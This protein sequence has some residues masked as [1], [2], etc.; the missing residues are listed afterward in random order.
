MNIMKGQL[1]NMSQST[2]HKTSLIKMGIKLK[3]KMRVANQTLEELNRKKMLKMF[4]MLKR[5]MRLITIKLQ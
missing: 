1:R 5:I 2:E 4:K 3:I